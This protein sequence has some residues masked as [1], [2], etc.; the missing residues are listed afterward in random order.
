M[1]N[2]RLSKLAPEL[3]NRIYEL[4]VAQQNPIE[5]SLMSLN[6]DMKAPYKWEIIQLSYFA[7]TQTCKAIRSETLQLFYAHSTFVLRDFRHPTICPLRVVAYNFLK[8]VGTASAGLA[9]KAIVDV[10]DL[11]RLSHGIVSVHDWNN[12][13]GNPNLKVYVAASWT[14]GADDEN[15]EDF[16]LD[17]KLDLLDLETSFKA[18]ILE[19]DEAFTSDIKPLGKCKEWLKFKLSY[20]Q[21]VSAVHSQNRA[22]SSDDLSGH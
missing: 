9:R 2:S 22:E 17:V 20:I 11:Y 10:G 13:A 4:V 7:L 3:R 1:E 18:L 5:V 14:W 21:H 6:D 16:T 15:D 19:V 8:R 12:V